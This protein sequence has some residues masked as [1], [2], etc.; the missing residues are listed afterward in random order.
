ML[1]YSISSCILQVLNTLAPDQDALAFIE[2]PTYF[3]V[4]GL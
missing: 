4:D 1:K 3:A 2:E